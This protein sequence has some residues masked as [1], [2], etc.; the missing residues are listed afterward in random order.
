M[1]Y[2]ADV[3]RLRSPDHM[4]SEGEGMTVIKAT[5]GLRAWGWFC[6]YKGRRAYIVSHVVLKR[7]NHANPADL[8]RAVEARR[9]I[10]EQRQ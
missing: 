1:G 6:H 2:L 7:T 10:E 9:Q 4:N 3:G 5:C 8:A